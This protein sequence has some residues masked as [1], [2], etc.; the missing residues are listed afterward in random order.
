MRTYITALM[1][2]ATLGLVSCGGGN[3][4]A[5]SGASAVSAAAPAT[6]NDATTASTPTEAKVNGQVDERTGVAPVVAALTAWSPT[7]N[8]GC[9]NS[10]SFNGSGPALT[11]AQQT[12][13]TNAILGLPW[14]GFNTYNQ[15]LSMGGTI[16]SNSSTQYQCASNGS[17]P[18]CVIPSQAHSV[19]ISWQHILLI[20]G[21]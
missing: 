19:T 10:S 1:L 11:Q 20:N 8:G 16:A 2:V 12:A 13:C 17:L 7:A 3:D 15:C 6:T 21:C 18:N 9:G 5:S 14:S 4:V